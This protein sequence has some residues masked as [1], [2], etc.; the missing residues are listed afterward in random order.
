MNVRERFSVCAVSH[1]VSAVLLQTVQE[2]AGVGQPEGNRLK[3][4]SAF[5]RRG[6]RDGQAAPAEAKQSPH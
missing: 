5:L 1:L 6:T 2:A 3:V 4:V